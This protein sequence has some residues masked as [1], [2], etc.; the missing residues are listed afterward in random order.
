MRFAFED[1]Q[2]FIFVTRRIIQPHARSNHFHRGE[3][4]D[5]PRQLHPDRAIF[6]AEVLGVRADPFVLQ[7]FRRVFH[8]LGQ[9]EMP[10]IEQARH[11]LAIGNP[12]ADDGAVGALGLKRQE[13]AVAR[14]GGEEMIAVVEVQ[15]LEIGLKQVPARLNEVGRRADGRRCDDDRRDVKDEPALTAQAKEPVPPVAASGAP[16]P[17][18]RASPIDCPCGGSC[19]DLLSRIPVEPPAQPP[20]TAGKTDP[21][22]FPCITT[23][24]KFCTRSD[25]DSLAGRR[26]KA[27]TRLSSPPASC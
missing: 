4:V 9:H 24:S 13:R 25:D 10:V 11:D 26:S 19:R 21:S 27:A 5:L 23:Q 14:L 6:P 20:K 7:R 2:I 22:A 3:M 15:K 1:P 12:P 17:V 8:L 16:V 18:L